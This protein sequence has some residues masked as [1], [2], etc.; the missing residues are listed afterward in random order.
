MDSG[1]PQINNKDAI[2]NLK[3]IFER[4]RKRQYIRPVFIINELKKIIDQL[5]QDDQQKIIQFMIQEFNGEEILEQSGYVKISNNQELYQ[6]A[7]INKDKKLI[8]QSLK[9]SQFNK[10]NE[11]HYLI[12]KNEQIISNLEEKIFD[13]LDLN[14]CRLGKK[15]IQQIKLLQTLIS[16]LFLPNIQQQINIIEQIIGAQ[17]TPQI[18]QF[19]FYLEKKQ[20]IDKDSY[21]KIIKKLQERQLQ[22]ISSEEFKNYI[23]QMKDYNFFLAIDSLIENYKEYREFLILKFCSLLQCQKHEFKLDALLSY[24]QSIEKINE[25]IEEVY[26]CIIFYFWMNYLIQFDIS[27]GFS[28]IQNICKIEGKSREDVMKQIIE[29]QINSNKDQILNQF[30]HTV[31][32]FSNDFQVQHYQE[33]KKKLSDIKTTI[34]ETSV[35]LSSQFWQ[36]VS[37]LQY[38]QLNEIQEERELVHFFW[39]TQF[40]PQILDIIQQIKAQKSLSIFEAAKLL[41]DKFKETQLENINFIIKNILMIL[42]YSFQYID[43]QHMILFIEFYLKLNTQNEQ[44][45]KIIEQIFLSLKNNNFKDSKF[46]QACE[47]LY[48]LDKTLYENWLGIIEYFNIFQLNPICQRQKKIHKQFP[49]G[50]KIA[51]EQFSFYAPEEQNQLLF[52]TIKNWVQCMDANSTY[53]LFDIFVDIL[54]R[55]ESFDLFLKIINEEIQKI[56]QFK[57]GYLNIKAIFQIFFNNSNQELEY[58]LLKYHSKIYPVPFIYQ[59]YKLDNVQNFQDIYEINDKLYYLMKN[60]INIINFNLS[61][62]QSKIGKTELINNIFYKQQKFEI[63][64][65]C[66]LNDNTI[67]LMFDYEFNGT[68]NFMVADTHGYIPLDILIKVLPLFQIWIIQIDTENELNNTIEII[69]SIQ[70]LNSYQICLLIR[71]SNKSQIPEQTLRELKQ[72]NITF[73][74]IIDLAQGEINKQVQLNEI[75]QASKY[76]YDQIFAQQDLITESNKIYLKILQ[77]FNSKSKENSEEIIQNQ[78]LFDT[79]EK[80]LKRIFE[81]DQ[82]FYDLEAFSLRHSDF[83]INILENKIHQMLQHPSQD[84]SIKEVE[85]QIQDYQIFKKYRIP[86]KLL[87]LFQQILKKDHIQYLWFIEKLKQFDEEN[88]QQLTLRSQNLI[89]E[90]SSIRV[91]SQILFSNQ[92]QELNQQFSEVQNQIQE[93]ENLIK[94]KK[95]SIEIFWR[96][97][98][99][100][101]S[102]GIKIDIDPIDSLCQLIRKGEPFELLDS[103]TQ[104]INKQFL[105]Q[106][107]EK[108]NKNKDQKVLILSVLGPQSSGKSTLLNKIFGCH[109]LE[110]VGRCTKGVNIQL[111]K[112]REKSTYENLFD[113][114]LILDTEGLQSPNQIDNEF[115]KKMSLFIL[116]VSDIILLT[117]KGDILS[118]FHKLIEISIQQYAQLIKNMAA[119]KQIVWCFNQN[120]DVQ[121]KG[122]FLEQIQQLAIHLSQEEQNQQ[123]DYS[124][125]IDINPKHIWVLG[126]TQIQNIWNSQQWTQSKINETFSTSAYQNGIKMIKNYFEK[127]QLSI[128]KVQLLNLTQILNSIDEIWNSIQKLPDFSEFEELLQLHQNIQMKNEYNNI[129]ERRSGDFEFKNQIRFQINDSTLNNQITFQHLQQLEYDVTNEVSNKLQRIQENINQDLINYQQEKKISKKIY[130]KF[131]DQLEQQIHNEKLACKLIITESIILQLIEYYKQKGFQDLSERVRFQYEEAQQEQINE[132]NMEQFH[133]EWDNIVKQFSK[134]LRQQF[135]RFQNLQYETIKGQYNEFILRSTKETSYLQLLRDQIDQNQEG[136]DQLFQLYSQELNETQFRPI[137]KTDKYYNISQQTLQQKIQDFD[138][139]NYINFLKFYRCQIKIK[140]IQKDH[141]QEGFNKFISDLIYSFQTE[142]N[143]IQQLQ[144]IF[145]HFQLQIDPNLQQFMNQQHSQ[146]NTDQFRE[147]QRLLMSIQIPQDLQKPNFLEY[148]NFPPQIYNKLNYINIFQEEKQLLCFEVKQYLEQKCNE[149]YIISQKFKFEFNDDVDYQQY[150]NYFEQMQFQNYN[151]N[152]QNNFCQSFTD[153]MK[154]DQSWDQL[155]T[156]TYQFI[157]QEIIN[158][159]S[160]QFYQQQQVGVSSYNMQ[161]VN[162]LIDKLN[163]DLIQNKFNKSFAY[164]GLTLNRLGERC[165]IFFSLLI[166]WKF[167]CFQQMQSVRKIIDQLEQSKQNQFEKILAENKDDKNELSKKSVRQFMNQIN[168]NFKQQFYKNSRKEVEDMINQQNYNP[169][170]ELDQQMFNDINKREQVIDYILNQ[171]KKISEYMNNKIQTFQEQLVENLQNKINVQFENFKKIISANAQQLQEQLKLRDIQVKECFENPE[172]DAEV[173]MFEIVFSYLQGNQSPNVNQLKQI[174]RFIF[175]QN[176]IQQVQIQ[177]SQFKDTKV[178]ILDVFVSEFLQTIQQETSPLIKFEE[179]DLQDQFQKIVQRCEKKCNFC[180]RICDLEYNHQSN[181]KCLN[182]HFLIAMFPQIEN[183]K[184]ISSLNTCDELFLNRQNKDQFLRMSQDS[185]QQWDFKIQLTKNEKNHLKFKLLK[186]WKLYG[187]EICK[188][189]GKNFLNNV[190]ESNSNRIHYIFM[191]DSSSSMDKDWTDIKKGV[192]GCISN[193]KQNDIEFNSEA[194]ISLILF[195]KTVKILKNAKRAKDIEDHIKMNHLGGGTDFSKPFK[196]ARKIISQDSS[197]QQYLILFYSD[198]KAKKPEEQL[199]KIKYLNKKIQLI[200]CTQ[201]ENGQNK[202][203]EEIVNC[204]KNE[205]KR[206]NLF[207]SFSA[208]HMISLWQIIINSR[209]NI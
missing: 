30:V 139:P 165:I 17:L 40:N 69:K 99:Q 62:N 19:Q 4:I 157:S 102:L 86:T 11:I 181:H 177:L 29:E 136:K 152:L 119:I 134:N 138:G 82:G 96:E 162:I 155:Y 129:F 5:D 193:I 20:N 175:N 22:L 26:Y 126:F 79:I 98:I 117:I 90:R 156:E 51:I 24:I 147:F 112:V 108:L 205:T 201:I 2:E 191:L 169:V 41:K 88:M 76:I 173:K 92:S 9:N 27:Q 203:L 8:L 184:I 195:N 6:R 115:D 43:K 66:Q 127:F 100:F 84:Q 56:S 36:N 63:R 178:Y 183:E 49:K 72:F 118:Q 143:N 167:I 140:Y 124:N 196:K 171:D 109:F 206:A 104:K 151:L 190:V 94:F 95:I 57:S 188:K 25:E 64:D 1:F 164:F 197:S 121:K 182:G 55:G 38:C 60:S 73:H 52:S 58:L 168:S 125:I 77:E 71:N 163:T 18:N 50:S 85:E 120:N 179:L 202:T 187:E 87:K 198:G 116:A 59:T 111:I 110:S 37:E 28:D 61:K 166:I 180:N 34:C 10:D 208:E 44:F 31:F 174:Y 130:L 148:N 32:Y 74:Q 12:S 141:L 170:K 103:D 70:H 47:Q 149:F 176:N 81:L 154:I 83:Q 161:K 21:K 65:N 80:E 194:K 192:R 93:I 113:Q 144:C 153:R 132:K 7:R 135:Y 114:I 3:T 45:Q 172:T 146:L 137:F 97:L 207:F 200:A 54:K 123:I 101:K 128:D 15:F 23:K 185:K 42:P 33:Y 131:Q 160:T 122:P 133:Q 105:S 91:S 14:E 150:Q 16:F 186:I 142:G 78:I 75:D 68:R 46:I 106:L 48:E 39:I 35:K 199:Q 159:H 145:D 189:L 67:D 13:L 158:Q 89:Q 209:L 107:I 53:Y 204:F